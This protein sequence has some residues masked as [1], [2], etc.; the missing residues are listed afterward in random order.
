MEA[1]RKS[2]EHIQR[3]KKNLADQSTIVGALKTSPGLCDRRDS[4]LASIKDFHNSPH[5]PGKIGMRTIRE[6]PEK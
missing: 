4:I 3:N 1:F 2:R 5:S 6:A